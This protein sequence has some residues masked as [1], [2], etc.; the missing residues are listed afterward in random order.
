MQFEWPRIAPSRFGRDVA[1]IRHDAHLSPLFTDDGLANLLDRYPRDRMGVYMFPP[2]AEGRVKALHGHARDVAGADLLE[3]VRNGRI[4]LNLRAANKHLDDYQAIADALGA[5]V[6]DTYGQRTFKWDVGVLI[7]SP[8]IHVHYH[9]DASPVCLVQIRGRKRVWLYPPTPPYLT[10]KQVEAVLLREREEDMEFQHA[11]DTKAAIIDLDPGMAV[12]WPQFGPHRV[13][14]ADMMN[15]SLSVEFMTPAALIRANAVYANAN[16]RRQLGL[17]P[18]MP[19]EIGP[20]TI[21]RAAVS[22]GIKLVQKPP[23]KGP[24]PITFRIDPQDGQVVPLAVE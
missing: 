21:V 20:T 13:Q 7:S 24:T 1:Q 19:Q 6:R 17:N 22:R 23:A 11:F 5:S 18:A 14:N 16:M 9:L 10:A 4:W 2:H 15:V 3:A 12:T 8:N